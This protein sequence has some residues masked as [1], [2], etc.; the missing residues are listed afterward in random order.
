MQSRAING[1]VKVLGQ[2]LI[3]T[4]L[5]LWVGKPPLLGRLLPKSLRLPFIRGRTPAN[6]LSSAFV[7]H[8]ATSPELRKDML[9][10][11][12]QSYIILAA[13]SSLFSAQVFGQTS[14]QQV[15]SGLSAPVGVTHA[16]GET[17]RMFVIEQGSGG[18]SRIKTLDLSTGTT[19][20]FLTIT[21]LQTGGERGLLGLAF[22]P[23]YANNGYFY[24]NVTDNGR[25]E[26]RRYTAN[27][28]PSTATTANLSS[29]QQVLSFN[30]PFSNH[31]GGWI[32]FNP[33]VNA[34]DPQYLYIGTGD[35]GSGGDPQNNSQDITNNLL[36][37]MLRIDVDGDDF[38]AS[39]TQNYAIPADNPFVGVTG[40]DEIWS[41][42]IRNPWR[43]SF[44]RNTGDLWIGDVGQ[45]A[46]EEIDFQPASSPGGEN[47]GWRVREGTNCFD[48]SAADGNPRCNDP[49]LVDPIYEYNHNGGSFGGFSVTG[50]YVYEG[51]ADRFDGQYF[52]ADYVTNHVWSIDPYSRNP[53]ASVMNRD[54]VLP[55]NTSFLNGI[56]SFGEDGNGELYI[57]SRDNGR[58]Y[59]FETSSQLAFWNGTDSVGTTGDG[60]T[61]GQAANWTR[62]STTDSAYVDQ[63]TVVFLSG[64]TIPNINLGTDIRASALDFRGSYRLLG[65]NVTVLSGNVSVAA[66]VTAAIDGSLSA[67]TVN[68][69]I[70]KK[71]AG[72]LLVNGNVGQTVVLGGTLGGSGNISWLRANEGTNVA[73]GDGIGVL[74]VVNDYDQSGSAALEIQVDGN[75]PGSGH[76]VLQVGG[77]ANID[78]TLN[79]LTTTNYSLT[80]GTIDEIEL[81][82]ASEVN[83]EFDTV[84]YDG[85]QLIPDPMLGDQSHAGNGL[86]QSVQ[87]NNDNVTFVNY[88]AIDGDANGDGFVDT[89]DFNVWNVNKFRNG[90]DWTTGDF[91]GDGAT[92]GTDF[93]IWNANKFTS[94]SGS[95]VPEPSGTLLAA[96][97]AGCSLF[98]LRRRHRTGN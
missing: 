5:V 38:P 78:G 18:T 85:V 26:I 40:D 23:D 41:Y 71:G 86:F 49:S 30:Q 14:L 65:G 73:P 19:S 10:Q 93:N 17:N 34:G 8:V 24:V 51:K 3:E 44:D 31:N 67:E 91:N 68:H 79:I 92:D 58:I 39:S 83:G 70:R 27:G 90:T 80:R 98:G 7:N 6:G 28:D 35:G 36:G 69:S 82:N 60:T 77:N 13:I 16:P 56:S 42:G 66:G 12:C 9:R 48:N 22:H 52:F 84:T 4:L 96:L 15:A 50:G 2:P 53:D 97:A 32:G 21:G 20:T 45:G 75:S 46:K 64:S 11:R 76:D 55:E 63:D 25:T 54:S 89:S 72:Q 94:V 62:G 43:N 61:W 47:Y 88:F 1:N 95:V 81:L 33:Q 57:V 59:R 87:F 37:K 29:V 74:S